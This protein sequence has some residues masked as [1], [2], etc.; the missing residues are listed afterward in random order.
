[1]TVLFS[2]IDRRC[3]MVI[4]FPGHLYYLEK[5]LWTSVE[6]PLQYLLFVSCFLN[7]IDNMNYKIP[8]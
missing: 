2:V 7:I 4:A 1:M 3:S 6:K 5:Y 8:R